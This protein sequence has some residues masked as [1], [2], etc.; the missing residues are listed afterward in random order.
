MREPEAI[1]ILKTGQ[2]H[3]WVAQNQHSPNMNQL[4]AGFV[5]NTGLAGILPD[6]QYSFVY[7]G[8]KLLDAPEDVGG[9]FLAAYLRGAR[10]FAQGRTPR[11]LDE[12]AKSGGIDP[13]ELRQQCRTSFTLD[14]AIREDAVRYYT[15]WAVRRGYCAAPIPVE[16][17]VDTRFLNYA[18]RRAGAAS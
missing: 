12:F 9:R 18:H 4:F 11:F 7:F 5:R 8:S 13:N 3:A 10:E 2:I 14:G 1:A 15:N 17:L 16:Q 6:Y